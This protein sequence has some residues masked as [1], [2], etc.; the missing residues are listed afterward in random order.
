MLFEGDDAMTKVVTPSITAGQI[1]KLQDLI[2]AALRK[3]EL[4]S[5]EVQIVLAK[6]GDALVAEFLASLRKR[7]EAIG[8]T[9]TRHVTVDRCR[10]PEETLK[11]TGRRLYLTHSVVAS[12]PRGDGLEADVI[13]FQLNRWIS[14][15]DL[16][17][18]Y[19][20]CGLKPADPYSLAKANEADPAFADTH[21]NCTHWKDADGKWCYAAFGSWGGGRGVDVH[22]NGSDWDDGWWF[23]GS[24]K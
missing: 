16:G 22:R 10:S 11:A 1:G 4:P 20:L 21:P 6:Q 3:C 5:E 15:N 18:E 19:E 13:F 14:D 7:V 24:R 17:R 8:S 23:A 12:M 9:I 2:G